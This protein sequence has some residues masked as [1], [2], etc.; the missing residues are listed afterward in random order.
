MPELAV[1]ESVLPSNLEQA[2][3]YQNDDIIYKFMENWSLPEEDVRELFHETKKWIWLS[4]LSIA[5]RDKGGE[6]PVLMITQSMIMLDEMWH[7]FILFTKEYQLFCKGFLGFY[8]NHSPTTRSQK[9]KEM[10]E[11]QA[12]PEG[13]QKNFEEKLSVQYSYIYDHLGEETLVK[14]YSDWTDKYTLEFLN[15]NRRNY[16][17]N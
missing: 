2:L 4:G 8:L 5:S 16:W 7:T 14:W 13:Y 15:A 6:G 17:R 1:G 3:A 10:A 11:L 9:E 12:D